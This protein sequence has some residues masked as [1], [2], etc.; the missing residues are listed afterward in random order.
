MPLILSPLTSNSM[1]KQCGNGGLISSCTTTPYHKK[2]EDGSTCSP[3]IAYTCC[4]RYLSVIV[5]ILI[6]FDSYLLIW[7]TFSTLCTCSHQVQVQ[8]QSSAQITSIIPS[9][10]CISFV[11]VTSSTSMG[12]PSLLS[13]QSLTI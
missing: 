4:A 13:F 5:H 8:G 2:V 11:D 6:C 12:K 3:G 10:I 7:Y 9:Q 1:Q